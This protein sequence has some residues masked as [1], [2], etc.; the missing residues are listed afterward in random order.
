MGT[1]AGPRQ[2]SYADPQNTTA[3]THRHKS[4]ALDVSR[5]VGENA[6]C[7]RPCYAAGTATVAAKENDLSVALEHDTVKAAV[8]KEFEARGIRATPQAQNAITQSIL[9]APGEISGDSDSLLLGLLRSGS[10]TVDA[11]ELAGADPHRL[12]EIADENL[13]SP[14]PDQGSDP[15]SLCDGHSVF[16]NVCSASQALL[17]HAASKRAL[18]TADILRYAVAP[19][20]AGEFGGIDLENQSLE[21]AVQALLL[22]RLRELFIHEL[23]RSRPYPERKFRERTDPLTSREK[24]LVRGHFDEELGADGKRFTE[25]AIGAL[26]QWFSSRRI[27]TQS[28]ELVSEFV[29]VCN[30]SLDF[31]ADL[32]TKSGGDYEILERSLSLSQRIN[33]ERDASGIVL[34]LRDNRVFA[35]EYTYRNSLDVDTGDSLTRPW[36]RL[37][38]QAVRPVPLVTGSAIAGFQDLLSKESTSE[39]EI[40]QFLNQH[41]ELLT[42][43]GGY[44]GA[45][46]HVL[47]REDGKDDMIPDYLLELPLGR[48]FDIADLKLHTARLSVGHRYKRVSHELVKAV[49]QLRS[50]QNF[51]DKSTNRKRF[52]REYGLEPFRPQIVVVMGRD[53]EFTSRDERREIEEQLFPTRLVTYDDLIA[54]ARSRIIQ[55]R[56]P[57]AFG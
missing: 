44:S 48:S 22:D 26:N 27:N 10:Y 7:C 19:V 49:A 46:P 32:F 18:E 53:S 39:A 13:S 56:P 34:C 14:L 25:Y 52:I 17:S 57:T 47:L 29:E 30:Y 8:L 38:I 11:L 6:F 43:F 28:S 2:P 41:P 51:F 54:Y 31:G 5:L 23:Y 21:D 36:R 20:G 37:G 45:H 9:H 4:Q 12:G 42:S 24:S 40:Q 35:A 55:P 15:Y 33:P 1:M 50:Y 3:C 16:F